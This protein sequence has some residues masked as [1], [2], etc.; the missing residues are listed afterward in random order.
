[1]DN[2][3]LI[4]FLLTFLAGIST[5]IGGLLSFFVKKE[6]IS[7]LALGLGFSA[8]VMIYISFIEILPQAQHSL[9]EILG[10]YGEWLA[11]T[12]FF[13]GIGITAL[14]DNLVPENINPHE[15]HLTDS[16]P[17]SQIL[18]NKLKRTGIFTAIAIAIHNF[19][20]GLV[21]FM[22][23]L[24]NLQW[25]ISIAAAIAIH[26]I[27]EGI[28]VALPIYHSTNNKKLAFTYSFLSG[29]AEPIGAVV[30]FFLLSFIL[31]DVS[32]GLIFGFVAGIMIYISFDELIPMAR[33]YAKGHI[34]I[35]GLS[36]GM[37]VMGASLILF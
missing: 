14:I 19:P 23:A 29:I 35:L 32:M 37:L 36:L 28:S 8:G 17:E 16:M 33:E 34:A 21:T 22:A 26:N 11:L 3:I 5:G 6:N 30:G 25:G 27:P 15:P 18:I 9:S 31:N 13:T 4:A 20:E 7:I 12:S 1:M 24:D 2:Q 10:K